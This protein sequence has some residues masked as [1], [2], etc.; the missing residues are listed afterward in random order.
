MAKN[1]YLEFES[2]SKLPASCQEIR[3]NQIFDEKNG[4]WLIQPHLD[5]QPFHV[6]CSFPADS[7][8][9]ADTILKPKM[10]GYGF[11]SLPNSSSG[12]QQPGCYQG[13]GYLKPC[14]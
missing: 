13:K 8:L 5:Y 11:T 12:C 4:L 1:R 9:P 6:N 7:S 14:F 10:S 2:V 3:D